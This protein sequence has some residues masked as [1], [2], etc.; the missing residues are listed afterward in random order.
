MG[1]TRRED[2]S[3]FAIVRDNQVL[4]DM[5]FTAS[6]YSN[7]NPVHS[8][9]NWLGIEQVFGE[10][11][12]YG[13]DLYVDASERENNVALALFVNSFNAF[14][15]KGYKKMFAYIPANNKACISLHQIFHFEVIGRLRTRRLLS[16]KKTI[17]RESIKGKRL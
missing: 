13:F 6:N 17:E 11:D 7:T 3:A 5:W 1:L 4:G 16:Y 10:K 8:D 2:N 14:L 12:V 9:L 15:Q